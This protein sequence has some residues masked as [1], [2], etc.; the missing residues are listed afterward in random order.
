MNKKYPADD[1]P[2][3]EDQINQ[4]KEHAEP[5]FKRAKFIAESADQLD[6]QQRSQAANKAIADIEPE[7]E[8]EVVEILGPKVENT[9]EAKAEELDVPVLENEEMWTQRVID[10][11]KDVE[12][13][14]DFEALAITEENKPH[15][16]D[17]EI[18]VDDVTTDLPITAQGTLPEYVNVEGKSTS[19]AALRGSNPSLFQ[20]LVAT[21]DGTNNAK[22]SFGTEFPRYAKRGDIFT[23]VDV[24]PNRVYKFNG[25]RWVEIKRE[26]SQT[27][28]DNP[29]Y[30]QHL[31][32]KLESGEYDPDWLTDDEREQITKFLTNVNQS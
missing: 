25:Y 1:G 13:V 2:L 28:L 32:S 9:L 4:I 18:T 29:G 5:F 20:A 16:V 21:A 11:N 19:L 15:T 7:V 14:T 22:V 6:E 23:R 26:V 31:I 3:S 24:L 8:E 10:E 12:P 30:V 17:K 27:Y